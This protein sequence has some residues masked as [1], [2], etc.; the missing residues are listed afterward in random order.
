MAETIK[1][2]LEEIKENSNHLR[3]KIR[4]ELEAGGDHFT[5]ETAQLLKCHGAYQE[6]DRD[7]RSVRRKEGK[8]PLYSVMV[9]SKIPGGRLSAEQ[10]LVHDELATRY[11]NGTL[12]ITTRQD[13]QFHCV[14]KKNLKSVIRGINSKLGTTF[15]SCGDTN[16]NVLACPAPSQDRIKLEVDQYVKTISDKL[17]P[18]TRAYHEI[19]LN[20][21]KIE[22][23]ANG[24]DIEPLYGKSY[25]PRKF[26]IAF[27]FPEDNCV[28]VYAN[29]VGIV[30]EVIDGKFGGFNI[31]AGGGLG[32]TFGIKNTFPRL[33]DPLCFVQ[34]DELLEIITMIFL[35]H[36]DFSDR[37]DRKHARLKYVIYERGF[38]W[39][40]NE[41]ESRL[42]KKLIPPHPIRWKGFETHLGWNPQGKGLWYFGVSVENGR[43]KDDGTMK[44][45]SGLC[46][47]ISRFMTPVFL[48][49]TQDILISGI[50]ESEKNELEATL[51]SYGIPHP[52]TLSLIQKNSM[53]CTALP[54]CSLAIT[55]AERALPAVVDQLE[56]VLKDL[57]LDREAITLRMTGCPNGCTRPY[58]AEIGLVGRAIGSYNIYLGGSRDGNRLNQE[59][60]TNVPLEKIVDIITPVL[61]LYK[62]DHKP[63]EQFGDFCCRF[64]IE[65][66][67]EGV[68]A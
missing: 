56:V 54:T 17:L 8:E 41:V 12:R 10:Y 1:S 30:P 19:W 26:K 11:G 24:E 6:D 49:A 44:L 42:G 20:G 5:N 46:A 16:R 36:R 62:T 37:K 2:V 27:A 52:D 64:G 18:K 33:A 66:L 63:E 35:I 28:D 13:F 39:F 15:G 22:T 47:I 60:A 7:V 38:D 29:D 4:E 68:K 21:E 43:I 32:M 67:R 51:I 57:G 65:K 31:L 9:R 59:Y 23:A 61:K 40:R 3:G 53:A 25:L 58:I 14:L 50:R 45:K 55:E 34:P 48:T